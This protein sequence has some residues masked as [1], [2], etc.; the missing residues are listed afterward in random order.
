MDTPN[1]KDIR[2]MTREAQYQ[3]QLLTQQGKF[4]KKNIYSKI[5]STF[6]FRC[7]CK[8]LARDIFTGNWSELKTP[9]K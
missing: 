7:N 1:R 5:V 9:N 8:R 3:T 6:S 4:E 2:D